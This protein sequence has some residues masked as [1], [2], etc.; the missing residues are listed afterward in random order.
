VSV[1]R[2]NLLNKKFIEILHEFKKCKGVLKPK[3]L[4]TMDVD[5][6]KYYIITCEEHWELI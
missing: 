2:Y 3:G 4:R 5:Q 6:G 1:N